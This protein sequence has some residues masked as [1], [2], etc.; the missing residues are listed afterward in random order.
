MKTKAKSLV[1]LLLA[2]C[3]VLTLSL[4]LTGCGSAK[5]TTPP[6]AHQPGEQLLGGLL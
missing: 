5:A 4:G 3:M 2:V 6:P 1:S